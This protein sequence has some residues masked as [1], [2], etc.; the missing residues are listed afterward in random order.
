MRRRYWLL[1]EMFSWPR[2]ARSSAIEVPRSICATAYVWRNRWAFS[3]GGLDVSQGRKT[4]R[5]AL[6]VPELVGVDETEQQHERRRNN[7]CG[8][9]GGDKQG[10]EGGWM[11][12][13]FGDRHVV[14]E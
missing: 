5:L 6:F 12:G 9:C 3:L 7:D 10:G 11:P 13:P 14:D 1:V 2:S 4:L 8:Q